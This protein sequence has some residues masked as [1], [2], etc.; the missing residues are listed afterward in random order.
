[1]SSMIILALCMSYAHTMIVALS[2]TSYAH[3]SY[4]MIPEWPEWLIS[5]NEI[6]NWNCLQGE[7]GVCLV[8]EGDQ[9]DRV[10]GEYME[11]IWRQ[12]WR[13]IYGACSTTSSPSPWSSLGT[14]SKKTRFNGNNSQTGGGG[15]GVLT[16]THLFMFVYQVFCMQ[17][18][19]WGAK[20]CFTKVGKW[21]LIN[22]NTSIY[23]FWGGRGG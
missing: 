6:K 21:Y 23:L 1:M 19:S 20:T 3:C 9:V 13:T 11:S 7:G 14:L 2:W 15:E 10:Y 5:I 22:L 12:T 18:S 16:Q 4:I 8:Q 17:K